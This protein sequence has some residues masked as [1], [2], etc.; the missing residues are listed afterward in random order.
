MVIK[1]LV[2]DIDGVL[3]DGKVV[4]DSKNNEYK[5]ISYRDM[6]A[7]SVLRSMDVRLALLTGEDTALVDV[8]G[9]RFGIADIRRSEKDKGRGLTEISEVLQIPLGN[10][11]YIGDS[12]RDAGALRICGLGIVPQDASKEAKVSA[13]VVLKSKGGSGVVH[14]ALE[15]LVE[16]GYVSREK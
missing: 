10:T 13:S 11:C 9:K 4:V 15:Y 6:D 5:S 2:L 14:E 12:D 8:I 16:N 7:V 3:T 1:L